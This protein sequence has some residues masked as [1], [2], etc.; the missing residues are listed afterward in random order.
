MFLTSVLASGN[1]FVD[2]RTC[3]TRGFELRRASVIGPINL[4]DNW[5]DGNKLHLTN[6]DLVAADRS[7]SPTST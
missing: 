6:L 3:L 1:V 4:E 2:D 5:G 7:C